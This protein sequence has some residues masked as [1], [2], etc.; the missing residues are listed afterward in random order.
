V[1]GVLPLPARA[2][3]GAV[4]SISAPASGAA[5]PLPD[6]L[7][8]TAGAGAITAEALPAAAAATGATGPPNLVTAPALAE[9]LGSAVDRAASMQQQQQVA[10]PQGPASPHQGL[11]NGTVAHAAASPAAAV[12]RRQA[13]ITSL[14]QQQAVATPAA[15]RRRNEVR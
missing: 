9:A 1:P 15:P 7:A 6:N 14:Q 12:D 5:T 13:G 2:A 10:Q 11:S 4:A 3:A 8:A